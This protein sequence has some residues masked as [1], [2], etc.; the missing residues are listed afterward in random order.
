MVDAWKVLTE[1]YKHM[2]PEKVAGFRQ[3]F[4]NWG[5][6]FRQGIQVMIIDGY[7]NPGGCFKNNPERPKM[8]TWLPVPDA[9]KGKKIQVAGGHYVVLPTVAVNPDLMYKAAELFTTPEAADWIFEQRAWLPARKS[10]LAAK[11]VS[12]YPGLD[13]YVKSVVEADELGA[14]A[15]DPI[16][17]FVADTWYRLR[18]KVYFGE[19][20]AEAAVTEMQQECEKALADVLAG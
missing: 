8:Y 11:D 5:P 16:T 19:M 4:T 12:R 14:I 9:R 17:S 18:E 7:W 13:W 20:T 3:A 15:V 10:Y 2:G 6:A 1:F